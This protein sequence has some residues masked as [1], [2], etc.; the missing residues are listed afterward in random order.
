[1]LVTMIAR[2]ALVLAVLPA[3]LAACGDDPGPRRKPVEVPDDPP[4]VDRTLLRGVLVGRT[5]EGA[6]ELGVGEVVGDFELAHAP[7]T[8]PEGDVEVR[9]AFAG[10]PGVLVIPGLHDA[11]SRITA[12][13][14]GREIAGSQPEGS[15]CYEGT[16]TGPSASGLFAFQRDPVRM[17]CG[18]FSGDE[19]GAAAMAQSANSGLLMVVVT[20]DRRSI[21]GGVVERG[22]EGEPD[23]V[24][25]MGPERI[26]LDGTMADGV[27]SGTWVARDRSGTWSV[28]EAACP[29]LAE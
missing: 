13:G 19:E 18:S 23:V 24:S 20:A 12:S 8:G 21:S 10:A 15:G 2:S 7:A 9:L 4:I 11:T 1:M 25:I 5:D 26:F 3:W 28:S 16:Y 27:A 29:S 17:L 6:P 14:D 22:A